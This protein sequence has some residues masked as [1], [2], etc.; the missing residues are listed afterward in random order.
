MSKISD[1]LILSLYAAPASFTVG[2]LMAWLAF[3]PIPTDSMAIFASCFGLLSIL[4]A[5]HLD[6]GNPSAR[7][8]EGWR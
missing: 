5:A 8:F 1:A 2:L 4:M 7:R 6:L 3:S